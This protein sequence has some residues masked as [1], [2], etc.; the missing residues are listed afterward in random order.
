[1]ILLDTNVLSEPLRPQPSK[2]VLTWLRAQDRVAT[3]VITVQ[4][5]RAGVEMLPEGR[6]REALSALVDDALA[7]VD[8]L[9]P[10]DEAAARA[11]AT[12]VA[13]LKRSGQ[14]VGT[15]ADVQ[16]SAIALTLGLP[17][18]TRNTRHFRAAGLTVVDPWDV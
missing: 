9:L 1:M 4:E 18:A 13:R 15:L 14:P 6:R 12:L 17:V 16:I 5:M 7:S 3:T 8:S 10:F 2:H 11:A